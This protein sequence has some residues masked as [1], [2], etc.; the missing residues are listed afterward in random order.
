MSAEEWLELLGGI[1]IG[2]WGVAGVYVLGYVRRQAEVEDAAWYWRLL[3]QAAR[4]AEKIMGDGRGVAKR[5]YVKQTMRDR[6]GRA[7]QDHE[8]EEAVWLVDRE[9]EDGV[10][11]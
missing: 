8:L 7:P 9:R 1:A 3:L 6:T 4:A 11:A 2:V 10:G 5:E